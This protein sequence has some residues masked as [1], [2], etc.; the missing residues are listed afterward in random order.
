MS[1]ES[2]ACSISGGSIS[3]RP[4]IISIYLQSTT[5]VNFCQQ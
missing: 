4:F 5:K 1:C 3:S 2:K